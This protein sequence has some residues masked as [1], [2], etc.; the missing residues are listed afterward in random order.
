VIKYGDYSE[1]VESLVSSIKKM[2]IFIDESGSFVNS[3]KLNSWNCVAA[4]VMP[5]CIKAKSK[6]VLAM[7]KSK[8]IPSAKRGGEIKLRHV[9]ESD[10]FQFL[11][12]LGNLDGVLFAVVTDA[13]RNDIADVRFH[14][15]E[16]AAKIRANI[17]RMIYEEGKR[18][19]GLLADQLEA[20]SPQLYVQLHC[21]VNM[22][23]DIIDRSL[24]YFVQRDP[25]TL[26][27][28]KWRID[29]KNSAKTDFENAFEKVAPVLLQSRAIDEPLIML[30]GAD[31]SALQP[32]RYK[33][34]EA[35]SYLSEATGIE[36]KSGLNIGKVLRENH[37]FEDS[38]RSEGI[39]IADLL[40]SGI[41]RCLRNGFEDNQTAA[42][43]LGRLM[44]QGQQ[45]RPPLQLIGFE[46]AV[47][48]RSSPAA[49]VIYTMIRYCRP[50]LKR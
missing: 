43:L 12:R 6:R 21:Q 31:Y 20:L 14:Q 28:F 50:M 11:T 36:I 40:A 35:P 7:L 5:E 15:K 47:V 16:Q 4:Y 33:E 29:Q 46:M 27:R 17:P 49:R 30:K 25:I 48:P 41:R 42:Q 9:S 2:N 45:R 44:I 23:F 26:R 32:Y 8:S 18:G 24:L 3:S 22:L 1:S 37:K 13:G 10:Y 19:L 34:G 39:Q 38:T